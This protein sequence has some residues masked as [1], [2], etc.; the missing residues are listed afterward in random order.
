MLSGRIDR[1]FDSR[2]TEAMKPSHLYQFFSIR[3]FASFL[4]LNFSASALADIS[5]NVE[6]EN[7]RASVC[8]IDSMH[9][10][11]RIDQAFGE[12]LLTSKMRW[13]NGPNTSEDCLSRAT[14]IWLRTRTAA[15][16]IR[17]IKLSPEVLN[18]NQGFGATATESPTWSRFFCAEPHDSASCDSADIT[19]QHL[20]SDLQFEGF[21]VVTAARAIKNIGARAQA[22]ESEDT[23]VANSLES[24]LSEAIDSALDPT[25]A[26]TDN[27]SESNLAAQEENPP[28]GQ[29]SIVQ[30]SEN[31]G[32]S[33]QE[34]HAEVAM[35]NVVSLIASTLAEY[36]AP[37][38]ECETPRVVGN[39]VQARS[40]CQLNFRSESNHEY[41][42]HESGR[43]QPVRSTQNASIDLTKD[44]SHI[45]DVR[46]S[47]EGWAAVVLEF[48]DELHQVAEGSYQTNR[49]QFTTS[50]DKVDDLQHLARSLLTLKNH[51]EANT[52]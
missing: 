26:A 14:Y 23:D 37:A 16:A 12:P 15:D 39:W 4:L 1:S 36:T 32:K 45:S 43:A 10:D 24:F 9:V 18:A 5:A 8:N 6:R 3:L 22:A 17:Y 28:E 13:V 40:T 52:P 48:K 47:D 27:D 33:Q 30:S 29:I 7:F 25:S 21:E 51:C 50:S 46:V 44:L 20:Q 19:R 41:L 49:W 42:C 34:K 38:H 31:K 2:Y 11:F 35:N